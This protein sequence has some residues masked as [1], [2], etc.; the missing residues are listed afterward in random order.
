MQNLP[1]PCDGGVCVVRKAI[2]APPGSVLITADY[3]QI[4]LRVMAHYCMDPDLLSVLRGPDDIFTSIAASLFSSR[5]IAKRIVYGIIYGMGPTALSKLA[6]IDVDA[7]GKFIQRFRETFP[8]VPSYMSE[9]QEKCRQVGHVRTFMNRWR[10][11][12]DITPKDSAKRSYAERQGMQSSS[13]SGS[14]TPALH[15]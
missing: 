14:N 11:I 7:A 6:E 3:E 12:P 4:E 9:V 5:Q 1:R 8:R 13:D 10:P 15:S 2:V